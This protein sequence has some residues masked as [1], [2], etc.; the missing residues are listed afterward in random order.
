M[1]WDKECEYYEQEFGSDAAELL[2]QY[3]D[4]MGMEPDTVVYDPSQLSKFNQWAY[5]FSG[6]PKV[7][8]MLSE[9]KSI[10]GEQEMIPNTYEAYAKKM[11]GILNKYKE[12]LG[13]GETICGEQLAEIIREV[14]SD[15]LDEDFVFRFLDYVKIDDNG[16]IQDWDLGYPDGYRK[17]GLNSNGELVKEPYGPKQIKRISSESRKRKMKIKKEGSENNPRFKMME[18]GIT[19]RE[20]EK[21]YGKDTA[22]A[23]VEYCDTM[24]KEIDQVADSDR[25]WDRFERWTKNKGA[26]RDKSG[27][28]IRMGTDSSKFD[29]WLKAAKMDDDKKKRKGREY[30]LVDKDDEMFQEGS[31]SH[32]DEY[33]ILNFITEELYE[34]PWVLNIDYDDNDAKCYIDLDPVTAF[35]ISVKKV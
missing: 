1:K 10:K 33:D 17:Y 32:K 8:N 35:E 7:I 16:E 9:N 28:K 24:E 26:R 29:H 2:M 20:I 27:K 19:L 13:K 4:Q 5:K 23:L 12:F 30:S 22:D 6:C 14:S 25:E 3:C 34:C 15:A 11:E 31:G 21:W 18:G